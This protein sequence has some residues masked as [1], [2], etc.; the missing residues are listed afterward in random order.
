MAAYSATGSWPHFTVSAD[1]IVQHIDTAFASRALRNAEGG[2][3]TNTDCVYQIEV[4]G[5]AA[6][7]KLMR[8]LGNVARLCRW[9]EETHKVAPVWPNGFPKVAVDG[10]DPGGH[11]RN[12]AVW[13]TTSGHYGHCHVPENTHWD[14][15][16]TADEVRQ[17]MPSP[18]PPAPL[19][20]NTRKENT[21]LIAWDP[22]AAFLL[23]PALGTRTYI[24]SPAA[25]ESL[26]AQGVTDLGANPGLVSSFRAV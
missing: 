13:D 11:N 3:E 6:E 15:G 24:G 26:K 20:L 2:V 21:M 12:A 19:I 7:P 22:N 16:Y 10:R 18:K 1:E 17:I 23:F 4:V 14:P 5:R 8:T 9:I 25:L